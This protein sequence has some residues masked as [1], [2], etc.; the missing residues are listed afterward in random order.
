[1]I[2]KNLIILLLIPFL[3][4][5]I[6]AATAK[7]TYKLIDNDIKDIK[8]NYGDVEAFKVDNS[9]LL[10][11]DTVSNDE[12]NDENK[13]TWEVENK[14]PLDEEIHGVIREENNK[15][16]LYTLSVGNVI[17]TC[18]NKKGNVYRSM[19]AIIYDHGAIL[20]SSEIQSSQQNIDKTT[21]YGE[22]DLN[23][24][25]KEKAE[26]NL[27]VKVVPEEYKDN[28]Y[29]EDTTSNIDFD[30]ASGVV[31][32]KESGT[33]SIKIGCVSVGNI[34]TQSYDFEIVKDGINVYDYETLLNCT[35]RSN[36]G[37]IVVLRKSFESLENYENNKDLGNVE[38]FGKYDSKT[39]KYDFNNEIYKFESNYNTEF[40]NKWNL[41]ASENNVKT[42]DKTV[43][44]GLHVQ[45][46]I[47]GNGY[48]INMHNLTYPK[49]T[50]EITLDD[51]SKMIVPVLM[52][53]DLYRGAI[54]F[55]ALGDH[56]NLP[57]I[58][59]LGQDNSCLYVDG[60]NILLNDINVKNC[61]F[62]N[63][64]AFLDYVGTTL[65][66][67]GN[68]VTIKN[69]R[70]SN[71]KNVVRAFST[72]N[73]NIDNSIL[74]NAR[75]FLLY[76]GSNEYIKPNENKEYEFILYD[77]SKVTSTIKE[78]FKPNG[79]GDKLLIDFCKGEFDEWL[80]MYRALSSIQKA[81]CDT[82]DLYDSNGN[83]I[84]KGNIDVNN[85]L[86]YRSGVSS[87]GLDTMFNGAYLYNNSPSLISTML[88]YVET[89]EGVPM[90]KLVTSNVA[91]QSFPIELN[92]LGNTKFYDYKE[93]DNIDISGLISENMIAFA[94]ATA[95]NMGIP[96]DEKT[97]KTIDIDK[98]FPIKNYL[99]EEA[100]ANNAIYK[101]NNKE[102][103][104]CPIAFYGGGYN[105]NKIT[106]SN[107]ELKTN[108]TKEM[109]VDLV[110]KY[111]KIPKTDF[112]AT[113]VKYIMMKAVTVTIGNDPFKFV[114]F[115]NSGY[116]FNEMP[117]VKE[118]RKNN[119]GGH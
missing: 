13:L 19:N 2:K 41:K 31:K 24:N 114:C 111:V 81:I 61:D 14:D 35:N 17:I 75:N 90:S 105:L 86:F 58:E 7:T 63:S 39:K 32:I 119:Y 88:G 10:E 5:L 60:N 45:K 89:Q 52:P 67:N 9:F 97:I 40:I 20:I 3:I 38:L 57:L 69:S 107:S 96:L 55:Y 56:N 62:S 54:P 94:K 8:W 117:N 118:L 106:I 78:F 108:V 48:T 87:I 16:Y 42:I 113:S 6:G 65:D 37:E 34:E 93:A 91:G 64:L 84:Y 51:G 27:N 80:D 66:I 115:K 70:L 47:Y 4:A 44:S 85:T 104:N 1:M 99:L 53:S 46:D 12:V 30:L 76:A 18:S 95:D 71:G 68:D 92:I 103:V 74:S 21:Y 36:N 23:N 15:F 102:Y 101:E 43:N 33:A 112:G 82:T 29:I 72:A 26:F 79:Y 11:A 49:G 100:K 22:Y 116:L 77:G 109:K 28:L 59:V 25:K 110:N 98:I 73:L 50:S 83:L